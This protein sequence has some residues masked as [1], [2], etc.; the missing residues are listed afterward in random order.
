MRLCHC[1][2][3]GAASVVTMAKLV[4]LRPFVDRAMSQYCPV[5]SADFSR[6]DRA[7]HSVLLPI[8]A[9]IGQGGNLAA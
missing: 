1:A 7:R 6:Y 9:T 5:P 8:T 4:M 2:T 3:L